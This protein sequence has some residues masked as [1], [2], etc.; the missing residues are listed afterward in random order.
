MW[1]DG[2]IWWAL[3][4]AYCS[5]SM[6][7]YES[8]TFF[9]GFQ[10]SLRFGVWDL[11]RRFCLMCLHWGIF[12]S[13][14]DGFMSYSH[15]SEEIEHSF[16]IGVWDVFDIFHLMYSTQRHTLRLIMDFLG[17]III[18]E[19]IRFCFHIGVRD[20]TRWFSLIWL[21]WSI[22]FSLV[23]I[24]FWDDYISAYTCEGS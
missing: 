10:T 15:S 14:D 1:L 9:R 13:D 24:D 11:D 20:M 6:T 21:H 7:N 12:L 23:L 8:Y 19:M 2:L 5:Q 18:S 3:Y 16:H 4:K 17:T 22:D